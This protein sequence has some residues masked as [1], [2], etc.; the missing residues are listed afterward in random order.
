MV[1]SIANDNALLQICQCKEAYLDHGIILM[2]PKHLPRCWMVESHGVALLV[3]PR[4]CC[5]PARHCRYDALQ[6]V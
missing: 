5:Q 6:V 2:Q 1:G 3:S 4:L